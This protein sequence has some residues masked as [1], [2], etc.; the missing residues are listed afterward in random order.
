MNTHGC[1]LRTQTQ[2]MKT[3]NSNRLKCHDYSLPGAYFVTIC[4]EDK[5][6]FFGKIEKERARLNV[7][8][9]IAEKSWL[10][11]P[12]HFKSIMMDDFI[13]MPNHLHGILTIYYD[14][15][16]ANVVNTHGCSLQ[17]RKKMYLSKVI[18]AFKSTV[19]REVNKKYSKYNFAW[20]KSF[21]DHIIRSEKAAE[22]IREYIKYNPLNWDL[23]RNNPEGF[24]NKF[25]ES[26]L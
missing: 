4:T 20:Q 17:E 2:K 1:S 14:K 7:I 8:G 22:E 11:I 6:E 23:D 10:E 3:S 13:V 19:S 9:K 5:K 16:P 18:G 21:Y 15:I 26:L 24:D 25:I 12:E